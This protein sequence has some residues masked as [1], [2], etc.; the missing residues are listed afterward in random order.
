MLQSLCSPST[1]YNNAQNIFGI[2]LSGLFFVSL[3]VDQEREMKMQI[4]VLTRQLRMKFPLFQKPLYTRTQMHYRSGAAQ[5]SIV[6]LSTIKFLSYSVPSH[7]YYS[8]VESL[9]DRASASAI[10]ANVQARNKRRPSPEKK[11]R[12]VIILNSFH[13]RILLRIQ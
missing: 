4:C 9:L 13:V 3:S 2:V 12:S 5:K 1:F 8:Y 11:K 10:S 7:L 6:Q